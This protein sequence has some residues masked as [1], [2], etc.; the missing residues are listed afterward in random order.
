MSNSRTLLNKQGRVQGLKARL[1]KMF[2]VQR[3]ER[4]RGK[5]HSIADYLPL[6]IK[7]SSE[8]A[9]ADGS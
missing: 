2:P 3:A 4:M 9:N 1:R 5:G 6:L 7:R 8:R